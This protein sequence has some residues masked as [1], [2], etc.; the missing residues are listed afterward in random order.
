MTK[1][2]D[3]T[4]DEKQRE[5]ERRRDISFEFY[6]FLKVL[7]DITGNDNEHPCDWSVDGQDVIYLFNSRCP[8]VT[9]MVVESDSIVLCEQDEKLFLFDLAKNQ[10]KWGWWHHIPNGTYKIENERVNLP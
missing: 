1:L 10:Q 4:D 5:Y 2:Q 9:R 7:N 3:M 8:T 6:K